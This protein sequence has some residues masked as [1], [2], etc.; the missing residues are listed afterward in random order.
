MRSFPPTSRLFYRGM[1]IG[2]AKPTPQEQRRVPHHLIDVAGPDE[3]WS[4]ATFQQAAQAAIASIQQRGRLPFLVGGTG[5]YV[6]SV[7]EGWQPPDQEADPELRRALER[8]AAQLGAFELH[9]RLAVLD[10]EAARNIQPQN[11]RRTVRALEVIFST[12]RRFSEQRTRSN[13]LYSLL[14]VGLNRPR[15]ELYQRIDQRIQSML[16]QGFVEEVKSLLE[17]GYS[18]GMP[19][20]SAIGY[21]EMV[22]YLE[23][24]TTLA[25]AVVQMKRMTRQ[26]VR[27]QANWFKPEDPNIH[28][29]QVKP[30]V[31]QDIERFIR[32]GEGWVLLDP[33]ETT[34]QAEQTE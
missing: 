23:G 24:L 4:L 21:R 25:E 26:F 1:D 30:G 13:P 22:D 3:V 12:G 31:V 20:L 32:S 9:D 16:D 10:P 27:R 5:Q 14:I 7:I 2:T 18:P 29:F 17:K 33:G 6:R 15:P 19:N 28:W 8:W 34:R 11:V